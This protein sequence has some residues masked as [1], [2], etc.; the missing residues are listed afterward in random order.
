MKCWTA[1]PFGQKVTLVVMPHRVRKGAL[2]EV[3]R[4]GEFYVAF[5]DEE[6]MRR[7]QSVF[8]ACVWA[9]EEAS[10]PPERN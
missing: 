8:D 7:W 4:D 10:L 5:H 1:S 6:D 9:I 2:V 3:E